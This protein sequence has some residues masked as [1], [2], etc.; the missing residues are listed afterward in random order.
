MKK[1]YGFVVMLLCVALLF[2]F[3]GC[4][5][6]AAT[7]ESTPAAEESTATA[8]PAESPAPTE[9]VKKVALLMSGPITDGGWNTNAYN[10]L[11]DC[12]DQFGIEVAYTENVAVNDQITLMRQYANKGF[13][14]I[15]GNGFQYEDAATQAASEF[16][17]V[18][19]WVFGGTVTGANLASSQYA[20]GQTG[21]PLGALMGMK[22]Q[23]NKIGFVIGSEDPTTMSEMKNME[24][25]A[26][27]YNPDASCTF[28]VTGDWADIQKA[29]EAAY[30]LIADG[31]DVIVSCLDA[32]T[33]GVIE[34]CVEKNVMIVNV[35]NDAYDLAP[36]NILS[37]AVH[38]G[39]IAMNEIIKTFVEG[40]F[41]GKIYRFGMTEGV[42]YIGKY[43]KSVTDTEKAEVESL[44]E[45]VK[46]GEI[47]LI[48]LMN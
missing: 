8:A 32:A 14:F 2:S 26:Q 1:Q 36:D 46:N 37:S 7:D 16:P 10:A 24:A 40:K 29:K 18:C 25:G 33:T 12:K 28:S 5:Q 6:P 27:K 20:M 38:D 30:A 48:N 34:A 17:D 22:T 39:R 21:Y 45:K 47:E 9:A 11:M 41:E 4:S 15:I 23:A 13:N 31:C 3:A 19:F 35:T 43:G 44:V 42:M